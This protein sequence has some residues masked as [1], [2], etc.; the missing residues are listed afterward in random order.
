MLLGRLVQQFHLGWNE[1]FLFGLSWT[2][3][4]TNI[5]K[6]TKLYMQQ[7]ELRL[8]FREHNEYNIHPHTL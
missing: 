2:T 3:R 5:Y 8:H 1:V 6:Y 7:F 4:I